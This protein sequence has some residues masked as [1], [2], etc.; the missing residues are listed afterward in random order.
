MSAR[1]LV[2]GDTLLDRDVVGRVERVCPDAPVPVVDVSTVEE[3]PGGAG[4]AALLAHRDGVDVVL[5][6]GLS[7]GTAGERV[8][9]LL[10]DVVEVHDVRPGTPTLCKTRVRAHGQSL[11]R[12]DDAGAVLGDDRPTTP[13]PGV[14]VAALRRLLRDCDAVLVSD[15]GGPMTRDP[16]VRDLLAECART[17]PVVW[18]PHPRGAEPVAGVQVA[19]PNHAEA[20]HF[21]GE[22]AGAGDLTRSARGLLTRWAAHAVCITDGERGSVTAIDDGRVLATTVV[23]CPPGTDTCG[24]GDRFAASLAAA[25]AVGTSTEAAV[26]EAQRDVGE[27]L[28]RGG[29][30][31]LRPSAAAQLDSPIAPVAADAPLVADRPRPIAGAAEPTSGPEELSADELVERVRRHGGTVVATGGCFDLLHAGHVALLERARSLGDCLVVLLNSD[32]S[33]RRLKGPTRPVHGVADRARLLEALACVDAVAVFEDDDPVATLARLR[34]DVW[35]KGGDYREQDLPEARTVRA[36]GG[37]IALV[38]YVEGHS[39]TRILEHAGTGSRE[40]GAASSPPSNGGPTPDAAT[41]SAT[42][43]TTTEG[44]RS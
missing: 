20:R 42:T 15:Y 16:A 38:P 2:L 6:T 1:L 29:V 24:A 3:R 8:R 17:T 40:T 27:W 4:L 14:D 25:L 9:S 10:E 21:A 30:A 32:A 11:L 28:R 37:R 7:A 22:P 31:S 5:A 36:L 33:V 35:V 26:A 19:T 12:L 39:T 34:P 18:D 43:S 23:R 44:E 13:V 41:D